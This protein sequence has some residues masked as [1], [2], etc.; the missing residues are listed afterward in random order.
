MLYTY[1]TKSSLFRQILLS[2][3]AMLMLTGCMEKIR[4]AAD[5]TDNILFEAA[6]T[7]PIYRDLPL[8]QQ[9]GVLRMITSYSS[10]TYF[11]YKGIQVGFEYELLREFTKE[12]DLALEVIIAGPG[13]NPYDILNSGQGDIIAAN[14]TITPE[15]RNLVDFSR[16]YNLVDQ[17][18]IVSD[19]LGF[20]PESIYDLQDTPITVRRNSSYYVRLKQLQDEG[21]PIKINVVSDEMDTETLLYQVSAGEYK[22]TVADNNLFDA[23]NKYLSGL[24]KGPLIAERD[25]IAWAIRNNAPDLES[26][27]NQ[28]LYKHFRF[29]E[30]G[31]PKRSAFLNVI[32]KKYFEG[33]LQISDYYSPYQSEQFGTISPYD[34][35]IKEVA[36]E[37]GLDWVM[38]TAITAQE[39]KFDPNS[40]SW[41]GAVGLMQ[42]L[43]RF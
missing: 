14:Y 22:A 38:L 15:R 30:D 7:E 26:K 24:V 17:L 25:T 32:R 21:F 33:S 12:N 31:T 5:E 9:S 34:N 37:Y 27:L 11:L 29:S 19:E 35:L 4:D 36:N 23:S 13:E 16:P 40:E 18:I 42:I 28:Y 39:S 6:I 2:V 3:I 10:G 20:V 41:A 8:I 43:P 1:Q